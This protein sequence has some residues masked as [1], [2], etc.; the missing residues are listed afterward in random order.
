MLPFIHMILHLFWPLLAVTLTLVTTRANALFLYL[1]IFRYLRTIVHIISFYFVYKPTRIPKR[2]TL[3]PKDCTIII[4]TCDPGNHGFEECIRTILNN[5]PGSVLIVVVG[6]P[7]CALVEK[8][9]APFRV[10]Y[11]STIVKVLSSPIANKRR[12]ICT[13]LLEVKTKITILVDDHVYWPSTNF[14]PT[15][16]APFEDP[17][18]GGLASNKRVRRTHS[19]FSKA[20]IYNFWGC[21]YLERHNFEIAAANALDGGIFCISG[22]TS[23]HRTSI[24]QDPEF[25]KAFAND[26]CFFG[27]VGPINPDDDNFIT[28]WQ[29]KKGWKIRVQYCEDATIETDCGNP[30]KFH[31]QC[32]RWQRS[33]WRSHTCSLFTDRVVWRVQPWCVYAVFI[34]FYF[35]FA[36]LF[37]AALLYTLSQTTFWPAT[38]TKLF[39]MALW[40]FATKMIKLIP[41]FCRYPKDLVLMPHYIVHAYWHSFLKFWALITWWDISW[42]GRN[43]AAVEVGPNRE[44]K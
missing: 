38:R 39:I 21:I 18:V 3:F 6:N 1:Y 41:H 44:V 19:G 35:N 5:R 26:F 30:V 29:V 13:A 16:L 31:Q 22:R 40:I 36:V 25:I 28:R 8:V 11:H 14:L 37:D 24:L 32:L 4:P 17:S 10:Q 9:V 34:A 12:Q 23:C 15:I 20:S 33:L 2:P 42:A 43:L 27:K 7:Q